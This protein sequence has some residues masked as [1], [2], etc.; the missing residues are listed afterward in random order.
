MEICQVNNDNKT[1]EGLMLEALGL[2][3]NLIAISETGEA[4][5]SNDR[6]RLL[7]NVIR[8]CAYKIRREVLKEK[9]IFN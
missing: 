3:D 9:N 8:D 1:L 4:I 6:E 5:S 7:F 2:S